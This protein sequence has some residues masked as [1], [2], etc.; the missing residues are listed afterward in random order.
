MYQAAKLYEADRLELHVN[1]AG[2]PTATDG[3]YVTI[4]NNGNINQVL[5]AAIVHQQAKPQTWMVVDMQG[6]LIQRGSFE[7]PDEILHTLKLNR[8]SA[9]N[10]HFTVIF[11][12]QE[13][14]TNP[15]IHQ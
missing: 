5:Q 1:P 7:N 9:G 15:F 11:S 3:D 13:R 4:R 6:R 2:I 10:Y 14:Q 12:N 8:L